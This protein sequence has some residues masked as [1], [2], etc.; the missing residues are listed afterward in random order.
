MPYLAIL[1][2]N[3]TPNP[4]FKLST[5]DPVILDHTINTP[6]TNYIYYYLLLIIIIIY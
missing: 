3:I 6:L 5:P 4:Y 1:G 2:A